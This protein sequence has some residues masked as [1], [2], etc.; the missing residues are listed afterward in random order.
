VIQVVFH[1]H[2][3]INISE[4]SDRRID[5]F[6]ENARRH[7]RTHRA[8]ANDQALKEVWLLQCGK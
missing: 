7:I 1:T 2:S 3:A 4:V 5:Q 8:S 6:P